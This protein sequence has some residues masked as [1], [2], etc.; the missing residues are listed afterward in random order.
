MSVRVGMTKKIS[1]LLFGAAVMA[2][3]AG[4]E[5]SGRLAAKVTAV[6]TTTQRGS[7][8]T[9]ERT[10][11]SYNG[12]RLRQVLRFLNS[13]PSGTT[14]VTYGAA[15]IDKLELTDKEGDRATTTMTYKD[16]RLA[17]TR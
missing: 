5:G 1:M 16:S 13:Q 14:T 6:E 10:E 2:G 15:G 9:I 8:T 11:A 12:D 7:T 3:C 4:E 17:R